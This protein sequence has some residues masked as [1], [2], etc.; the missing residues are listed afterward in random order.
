M[1]AG[2]DAT[3][4]DGVVTTDGKY[5]YYEVHTWWTKKA[6]FF[7]MTLTS[8][9]L[10]YYYRV[11]PPNGVTSDHSCTDQIKNY[12][13]SRTFS[14]SIQHWASSHRGYCYSTI[15]KTVRGLNVQ[16]SGVQKLVV[17]GSGIISKT[18]P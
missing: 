13:P 2:T 12:V 3:S 1:T 4:T 11:T 5:R 10:D 15:T 7:G 17:G 14:Y 9:R 18:G 16:T 8:S 6:S